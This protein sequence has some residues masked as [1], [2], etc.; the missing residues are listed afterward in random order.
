M[1]NCSRWSVFCL[2]RIEASAAVAAWRGPLDFPKDFDIGRVAIEVKAHRG[3][4]APFVAIASEDQLD[5]SGVDA[6]FLYV[7]EM[8]EVPADA[9]DGL[10]VSD[11]AAR[12]RE[13]IFA[14]DPG[15]AGVLETLLSAAGLRPEDDYSN[16][17]WLPGPSR[18]YQ[19]ADG[20]PRI[21]R[22]ELRSGVSYVRYSVSLADCQ[23]FTASES[24]LTEA[25]KHIGGGLAN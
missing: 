10:T 20:F 17:H 21:A 9:A 22:S 1:E 7:V 19:V 24:D 6:L 5:E 25:L 13:R 4:G 23:L 14:L 2:P 11:V 16:F 3:G 12:V 15:A 18:L 8:D